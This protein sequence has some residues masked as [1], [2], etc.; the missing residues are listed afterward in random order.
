MA[1]E[2]IWYAQKV[3]GV[4]CMK[5]PVDNFWYDHLPQLTH[6]H[7]N[8]LMKWLLPIFASQVNLTCPLA[9]LAIVYMTGPKNQGIQSNCT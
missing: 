3:C 8:V 2:K 7:Q 9:D 4:D 5:S 1:K 6:V